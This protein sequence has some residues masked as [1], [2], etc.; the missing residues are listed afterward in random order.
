MQKPTI[1]D[2]ANALN[3]SP[4]T[5]S[6]AL[7]GKNGVSDKLSVIIRE[8]AEELGYVGNFAARSLKTSQSKTIGVTVSDI[9]NP[10][11]L[12]FLKGV[13]NILFQRGYKFLLTDSGEN[14]EKE[15][16]YLMWLIEHGVDGILASPVT[17]TDGK[18]NL[19]LYKKIKNIGIPIVF[20]DRV[21]P[22][23]SQFD[24]VTV[25]NKDS[26]IQ[27]LKYLYNKGHKK[28]GIF[29]SKSGIYTIEQ[30]LEGFI[31]GCKL[32][33]IKINEEWIAKDLFPEEK[34]Y[35]KLKKL[36]KNR[37]LPSAIIATNNK[38]TKQ[39]I[40]SSKKLNITIPTNLSIM[41]YDDLTENEIISPPITCIKQPVFEIGRIASTILLGKIENDETKTTKI[42]LKTE[43]VERNSII[44]FN[45]YSS[46]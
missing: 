3:I 15:K 14:V 23:E 16:I 41:G 31:E 32:L 43:I 35:D 12:D 20:Y 26:I 18:N 39:L 6:R 28:I 46:K 8:K 17:E 36:K 1:K 2:I 33:G 22:K 7:N 45:E 29:L 37:N 44:N 21:F 24:S 10:F 38:I 40:S 42:V 27:A 25:D 4:S 19:E 34:T 13:D 30:R 5:V 11:F 9:R